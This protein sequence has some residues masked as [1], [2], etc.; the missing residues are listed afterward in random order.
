MVDSQGKCREKSE[1][2]STKRWA[3]C[4]RDDGLR[5]EDCVQT[6]KKQSAERVTLALQLRL[7][8]G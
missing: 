5:I 4:G 3:R 8:E 7:L 1:T 6:Q 2:E